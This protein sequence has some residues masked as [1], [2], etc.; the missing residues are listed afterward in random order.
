MPLSNVLRLI[1]TE[2]S[3]R[4]DL[5]KR[6]NRNKP[7]ADL[8]CHRDSSSSNHYYPHKPTEFSFDIL[9]I[10]AAVMCFKAFGPAHTTC[11]TIANNR[12]DGYLSTTR[13]GSSRIETKWDACLPTDP[14]GY[15]FHVPP[16]SGMPFILTFSPNQ[17]TDPERNR[18]DAQNPSPYQWP[19]RPKLSR[20]EIPT[21]SSEGLA[22]V[23]K[24]TG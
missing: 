9:R 20:L 5:N 17:H 10:L 14:H 8:Q 12:L 11:A 18:E 2:R 21:Y 7:T 15:Y 19:F 16:P 23:R 4:D 1:S 22:E 3:A 6:Q 13:N 24:S